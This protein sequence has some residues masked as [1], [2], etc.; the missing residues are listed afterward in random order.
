MWMKKRDQAESML[1]EPGRRIII[2]VIPHLKE[3]SFQ[4]WKYCLLSFVFRIV[5]PRIYTFPPASNILLYPYL[6]APFCVFIFTSYRPFLILIRK[7]KSHYFGGQTQYPYF[8]GR[9]RHNLWVIL[10]IFFQ[11]SCHNL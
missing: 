8:F 7:D 5:L 3:T 2:I 10:L 1:S 11:Y 6:D 4:S 9:S